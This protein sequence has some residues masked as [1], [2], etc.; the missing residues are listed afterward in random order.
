MTPEGESDPGTRKFEE[1]VE[2]L[3]H[4]LS[5]AKDKCIYQTKISGRAEVVKA[6][7]NFTRKNC[8]ELAKFHKKQG[9]NAAGRA[10]DI[11]HVWWNEETMDSILLVKTHNR[12]C[13][14]DEREDCVGCWHYLMVDR[15]MLILLRL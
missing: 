5:K 11:P 12:T 7:A 8:K 9:R 2:S 4:A 13:N 10:M 3:D 6:L 1:K 15:P 14:H